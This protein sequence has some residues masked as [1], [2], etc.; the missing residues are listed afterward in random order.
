MHHKH[1]NIPIKY[2]Y[3]SDRDVHLF[4]LK[5]SMIRQLSRLSW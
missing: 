5:I 1:D 3:W 4:V 2:D